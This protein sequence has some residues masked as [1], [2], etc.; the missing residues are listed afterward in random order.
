M[1]VGDVKSNLV[2]VAAEAYLVI[3][4]PVGEEWVIH[5]IY[6]ESDAQLEFYDGTNAIVFDTH[7]GRGGWLGYFFHATNAHYF[8]VKNNAGTAQ[9]MGYDGVQTK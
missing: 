8:R 3:Q 1:A 7:Y 4:P 2:S 9:L 6:H 5:N